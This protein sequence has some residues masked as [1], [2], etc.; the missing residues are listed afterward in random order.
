M[1][2]EWII[3]IVLFGLVHWALVGL[4]LPDLASGAK[5]FGG[6]KLPWV[7]MILFIPCLGSIVFLLFHPH[8]LYPHHSRE[9]NYR[10]NHDQ[11]N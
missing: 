2:T 10:D 4:L 5:V 7:L 6:R 8:V 11:R 3:R 9:E 1:D